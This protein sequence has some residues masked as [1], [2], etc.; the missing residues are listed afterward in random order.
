MAI[1]LGL[2]IP[3]LSSAVLIVEPGE[4]AL[5][6]RFGKVV[7]ITNAGLAFRLPAPIEQDERIQVTEM[8]R[9]EVPAVRL[10]TGDTNLVEVEFVVQFTVADPLLFATRTEA[11]EALVQAEVASVAGALVRA[12]EVD[13]LLTTGRADLQR[14]LLQQTQAT[15]DHLQTGIRLEGVEVQELVP[16]EAVVDA[17]NDV[18]SARGDKETLELAADAYASRLLP[19]VRGQAT[20][21]VQHAHAQSSEV[22]TTARAQV[23]RFDQLQP[24]Y[25]AS[26]EATRLEL[27]RAVLDDVGPRIRLVVAPAGTEVALPIPTQETSP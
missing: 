25:R 11:P 14:S 17:F 10:L 9:V 24:T 3:V 19:D 20:G 16:P 1:V 5:I 27:R 26:R 22:L 21:H 7:R 12:M 6:S 4:V 13:T 8:R 18:S 15:L 2:T 23:H